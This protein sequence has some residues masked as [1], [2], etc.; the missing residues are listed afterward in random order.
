MI[1][2]IISRSRWPCWLRLRSAAA[3]LL[4]SPVRISL[5]E[6][7]F[8]S[9]ICCVL[10]SGGSLCHELIT[11]SE[12]SYWV[13]AGLTVC[14][15]TINLNT[16]G[17]LA[18]LWIWITEKKMGFQFPLKRG[19]TSTL[20]HGPRVFCLSS[21]IYTNNKV[22]KENV[23]MKANFDFLCPLRIIRWQSRNHRRTYD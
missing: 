7:M 23:I 21:F 19:I 3:R 16:E 8:V 18:R 13:C 12:E 4:E 15:W 22:I 11:R 6:W 20:F 1:I 2:I 17:V 10:C 5:T 14:V 9:D